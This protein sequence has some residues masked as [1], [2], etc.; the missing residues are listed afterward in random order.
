MFIDSVKKEALPVR[1]YELYDLMK[2]NEGIEESK[3][4]ALL[5][6]ASLNESDTS[7]F[8]HIKNAAIKLGLID[9]DF[10]IL[11]NANIECMSDFRKYCNSVIFKNQ[12]GVFYKL[13]KCILDSN[14]I[15][16]RFSNLTDQSAMDYM[17]A[18]SGIDKMDKEFLWGARFWLSFLGVMYL[19][20]GNKLILLPNM[21]VALKDFILCSNIEKAKD[22]T[23]SEF[24]DKIKEVGSVALGGSER[25]M[26]NLAMSN[27]L[28]QMHDN[29]EIILKRNLDSKEVWRLFEN[30]Q[31]TIPDEITHI[32]F[33]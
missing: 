10:K 8:K 3:A 33:C 12:Q 30:K 21:Y 5:E 32:Y 28:R 17:R 14:D 2:R 20:E 13:T 7:N 26:I 16:Y 22:Y 18:N 27:A 29:N 11:S 25:R 19:T 24:I 31:H 9:N 6:P 15:W 4:K 23:V 1:V